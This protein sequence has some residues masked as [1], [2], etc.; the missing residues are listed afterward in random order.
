MLGSSF[1]LFVCIGILIA[2]GINFAFSYVE[3]GK[4]AWRWEFLLTMTFAVIYLIGWCFIPESRS[5]QQKTQKKQDEKDS[6]GS[7]T[8]P[9]LL[10]DI[11]EV[12]QAAISNKHAFMVG[13]IV[14]LGVQL[15][16]INAIMNFAPSMIESMGYT[17]KREKLLGTIFIGIWNTV[18]TFV[19]FFL[20]D[21][22]GRKPLLLSG[23]SLM[24]VGN[25]LSSLANFIP[26]LSDPKDIRYTLSIPGL[27][28][29]VLGFETGP[30]PGFFVLVSELYSAEVRGRAMGLIVSV[31]WVANIILVQF[32]L[33]L[34][35]AIGPAKVFLIFAILCVVMIVFII[36]VVPETKGVDLQAIGKSNSSDQSSVGQVET[37]HMSVNAVPSDGGSF[38]RSTSVG[39]LH[40][41]GGSQGSLK[42]SGTLGRSGSK[43]E[44]ER[45]PE[46]IDA[47]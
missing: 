42:G 10:E 24:F 41:G 27:V 19:S 20:V 35:T 37:G 13:V 22:F 39:S 47:K 6:T 14:A 2:Y 21:K 38:H 17:D 29:F 3:D 43:K 9:S 30:G 25:L 15:T 11:K 23:F 46:N 32:Y 44:Y 36:F 31:N 12:F 7:V 26:G 5:H 28:I 16:G 1:Q 8:S 45:I 40:H 18:S 34:V 4:N 33:P